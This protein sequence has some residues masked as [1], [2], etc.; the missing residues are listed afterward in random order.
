MIKV[1]KPDEVK[2]MLGLELWEFEVKTGDGAYCAD[3]EILMEFSDGKEMRIYKD[4]DGNICVYT[5]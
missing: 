5:D 1:E 2:S 4:E 3:E